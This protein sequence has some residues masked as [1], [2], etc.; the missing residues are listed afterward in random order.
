MIIDAHYHLDE[1][2]E[3]IDRLV[4]QMKINNID[5]T[6]LIAAVCEPFKISWLANKLT[7]V[8]S[9]L[10]LCKNKTIGLHLYNGTVT[11][12]GQTDILGK[13]YDIYELPDNDPVENAIKQHPDKFYGWIF[14]NPGISEEDALNEIKKRAGTAGWVGVK[15][16]PFWHRY[17]VKLIESICPYCIEKD[18]PLLIHLGGKEGRGDY[19]CLPEKYPDLKIIYA[20]AG[21]PYFGEIWDYI[22]TKPNVYVDLSSPYLNKKLRLKTLKALGPEKCLYGSD[23]PFGYYDADGLYD[24]SAILKEIESFQIPG[25]EK[26]KILAGNFKKITGV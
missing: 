25:T 13:H 12:D 3:T 8:L 5:K 18:L 16:H 20:H 1:R 17:P 26:D 9:T 4:N 14:V 10:L 19:K 22:K 23:G 21:L 11:K 2:L 7:G 24:H 15:C 6:S